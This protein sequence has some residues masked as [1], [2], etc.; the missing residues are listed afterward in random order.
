MDGA[1]KPNRVLERRRGRR[2]AATAPDDIASDGAGILSPTAGR[3]AL[4]RLERRA[5]VEVAALR[6][7]HH[8]A[9]RAARE[10]RRR[11]S[12]LG[13]T[14]DPRAAA[15]GARRR[16]STGTLAPAGV[17]LRMPS[18]RSAFDG[19]RTACCHRRLAA[20]ARR[21]LV[22]RPD[23]ARPQRPRWSRSI[24]KTGAG[25]RTGARA[26]T[27]PSACCAQDGDD[28]ASRES[29]RHRRRSRVGADGR[30]RPLLTRAAGL[31]RRAWRRRP[32]AASGSPASPPHPAGRVRAA[33]DRLPAAHDARRSSRSY[34]IAP[35][36]RSG[37]SFLEPLQGAQ[38]Q[39]DG[40]AEAVGAAALLRAGGPARRADGR[41][42]LLAAQPGRRHAPR[43]RRRRPSTEGALYA[44]GQGRRA[45]CC[46]SPGRHRQEL[47]P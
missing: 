27:M 4:Y 10:R 35:A 3:R 45:A 36:L 30:P 34:W 11:A 46:G 12:A 5:P 14:R 6:R 47:A 2:R 8:R 39:A 7:R 26:A 17:P 31:S 40:R 21:P 44:A 24:R 16:R 15:A 32:A 33:R 23:G 42:D 22:P 13:G 19:R 18:T 29:W 1:L 43:H 20:A 9:L 37:Q 41:R 28:A 38:R 25:A